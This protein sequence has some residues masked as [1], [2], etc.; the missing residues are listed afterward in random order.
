MLYFSITEITDGG[1]GKHENCIAIC[2]IS[3]PNEK[4]RRFFPVSS[5]CCKPGVSHQGGGRVGRKL[6]SVNVTVS[7]YGT[8]G[9]D[10]IISHFANLSDKLFK[11]CSK[12]S[13][14]K[15]LTVC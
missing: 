8:N 10:A 7:R 5:L 1:R 11:H 2:P 12:C 4:T 13:S 3:P 9:S 15:Q 14:P 6:G